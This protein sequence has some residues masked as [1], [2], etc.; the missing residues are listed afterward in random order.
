M[1][2]E[3]AADSKIR[4]NS[5]KAYES[6]RQL[7]TAKILPSLALD[8]GDWRVFESHFGY[9]SQYSKYNDRYYFMTIVF[10]H[11]LKTSMKGL[12]SFRR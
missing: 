10:T 12:P 5:K 1:L 9:S 11:K 2:Q 4:Q 8:L 3:A 6:Y 7:I